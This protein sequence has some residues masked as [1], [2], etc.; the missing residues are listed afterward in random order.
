MR[1]IAMELALPSEA[2]S[3]RVERNLDLVLVTGILGILIG[4]FVPL[5]TFVVDTLL[6]GSIA[7]SLLV[8]MTAVYLREPLEFASFPALL[9]LVTAFRLALNIATTRLILSDAGREGTLAAGHVIRAFGEFVAGADAVVGFILFSI[10]MIVQFVVITKGAGRIAE[11]SARFALDALPGKQMAIDADLANGAIPEAEARE[12]RTRLGRE[13]DF[14]G[15][16]DGASKFVR[17]DAIA[18]MLVV[19]VN[20][21]AGFL[22]GYLRYGMS[23]SEA[24]G[25]FTKLTIGDGLVTQVPAVIVSIAAGLVVTRGASSGRLGHDVV[26][27]VFTSQRA[28]VVTAIFLGLLLLT[29]LP[30]L[31]LAGAGL[32]VGYIAYALRGV[33]KRTEDR[34]EAARRSAA[35]PRAPERL[36][37]LLRIDPIVLEVGR[38]WE[39]MTRAGREGFLVDRIAAERR[40]LVTELGFILPGVVYTSNYELRDAYVIHLKGVPVARGEAHPDRVLAVAP[41][42]GAP[43]L[44]GGSA[45]RD[46]G[47]GRAGLWIAPERRAEA[48]GKG[49]AVFDG[50][51]V[52][53]GH[54]GAVLRQNAAELLTR[55]ATAELLVT[56]RATAKTVVEE[57]VPGL[58]KP[59]E[60]QRVLQL[61]LRENVSIR[62]LATILEALGDHAAQTKDAE[63]LAEHARAALGRAIC[64]PLAGAD[65]RLHVAVVG[66][67]AEA[68]IQQALVT[69]EPG[70]RLALA[71]EQRR[72]WG[73]R[74]RAE[75][76][77]LPAAQPAR[78]LLCSAVVR[79]A[80][81][82]LAEDAGLKLSV[83]AYEEIPAGLRFE[84]HGTVILD[85]VE[86]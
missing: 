78:V 4:V 23:P 38:R 80:F 86:A 64:G 16:M 47:T 39:P 18:G 69:G 33:A 9:L 28:L 19:G 70:R 75:L 34:T 79:R 72:A 49:Y 51:T 74:I 71:E 76:D 50:L 21:L 67:D 14:Y 37:Q 48:D 73:E 65:G 2:T 81:R 63:L 46:E 30:K 52:V 5:P 53:V 13:S 40:R 85:T 27:Q 62:D 17:G 1:T 43:P 83:L 44:E 56:H 10:I 84:T 42:A 11:V 20:L 15:A 82:E 55:E 26:A 29:P 61:L 58:L 77:R 7:L 25:V 31:P 35:P 68:L 12:R 36:D 32:A 66:P 45:G 60:L 54:V 41:S 22:I 57:V 24:L 3:Q 6:V 59:G 8:L